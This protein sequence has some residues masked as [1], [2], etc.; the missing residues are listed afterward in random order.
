MALHIRN[1]NSRSNKKGIENSD[2]PV[3]RNAD[4]PEGAPLPSSRNPSIML[5]SQAASMQKYQ[6]SAL[7][8]TLESILNMKHKIRLISDMAFEAM[9]AD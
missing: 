4:D 8:K 7:L 1:F 5:P 2:S 3:R 6:Q 9:D